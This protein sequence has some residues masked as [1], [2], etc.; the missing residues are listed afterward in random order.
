M[1]LLLLYSQA[2]FPVGKGTT[3]H[4][5]QYA[6]IKDRFA[7]S[8][9]KDVSRK[10]IGYG[11]IWAQQDQLRSRSFAQIFFVK[12]PDRKKFEV[13]RLGTKS[14][15]WDL[16]SRSIS[17]KNN[18]FSSRRSH[19]RSATDHSQNQRSAR[20][21]DLDKVMRKPNVFVSIGYCLHRAEPS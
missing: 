21:R 20:R 10:D 6:I 18:S 9:T 7:A 3:I 17:R 8:E 14:C 11:K 15:Y 5:D 4:F 19:S 12:L 13:L 16:A 2:Y 1:P